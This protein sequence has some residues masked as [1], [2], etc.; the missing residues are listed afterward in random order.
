MAAGRLSRESLR[1]SPDALQVSVAPTAAALKALT[2]GMAEVKMARV[3]EC[4]RAAQK[5]RNNLCLRLDADLDA[6]CAAV[7]EAVENA[8]AAVKA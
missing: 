1:F 8:A 5:C 2:P 6:G 3:D 7:L 4:E